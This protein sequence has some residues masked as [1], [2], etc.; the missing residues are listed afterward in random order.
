MQQRER[1]VALVPESVARLI[2]SGAEVIVERGAGT[3]AGFPAERN[4][5]T[6]GEPGDSMYVVARG[7]LAREVRPLAAPVARRGVGQ[8]DAHRRDPVRVEGREQ[9]AAVEDQ[10][11]GAL[12]ADAGETLALAPQRSGQVAGHLWLVD[13]DVLRDGIAIEGARVVFRVNNGNLVQLGTE[14]LPSPGTETPLRKIERKEALAV[15]GQIGSASPLYV[16]AQYYIGVIQTELGRN[17]EALEAYRAARA[18]LVEE[19]GAA[20]QASIDAVA[21]PVGLHQ[22]GS[23]Q[24]LE[25]LG[26]VGDRKPGPARQGIDGSL[27]LGR[28]LVVEENVR[29]N[30]NGPFVMAKAL[31]SLMNVI[32][33]D[34]CY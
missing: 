1:R 5:V 15:L 30:L 13:Y 11:Q 18:T 4:I 21:G 20:G 26:G 9:Q 14:N 7:A 2:K 32:Y 8:G 10:D 29:V 28:D 12:E 33:F 22:V 27:A 24:D 16:P 25:V 6:I 3:E 23:T 17:D 34:A 19:I 31:F